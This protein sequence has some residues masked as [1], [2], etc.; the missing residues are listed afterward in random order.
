MSFTHH[1]LKK[2]ATALDQNRVQQR[3]Q[4]GRTLSYVEGWFVIQEANRIFGFDGWD[5]QMVHFERCFERRS[6][7]G[8]VCGYVARVAI[9]VRAG[10]IEIVREGTGFGQAA[11]ERL[12][13]AHERA[14]KASETDATK[15]ALATFGSRFG[16]MLY[17]K[18]EQAKAERAAIAPVSRAKPPSPETASRLGA[19]KPT[20][21]DTHPLPYRLVASDGTATE[22]RTPQSFCSGLR[23]YL[24]L[25]R[26]PDEVRRL[27]HLNQTVIEGLRS[28]PD[29]KNLH[30]DHYADILERLFE[31]RKESFALARFADEETFVEKPRPKSAT[32]ADV[33]SAAIEGAVEEAQPIEDA[34]DLPR[35]YGSFMPVPPYPS[36]GLARHLATASKSVPSDGSKRADPNARRVGRHPPTIAPTDP[37][38][39]QLR[40]SQISGGFSIDKSVLLLPSERRV[41][42]KAHL[43]FVATKPCLICE[44]LP[45]HAHHITFAQ[46]RGLSQKVSDEFTV[47]LCVAHHNDLHAFH[48]EASW[49]RNQKIEPLPIAN[50]LWGESVTR[51][52]SR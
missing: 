40:R 34:H 21:D 13:D 5:R 42:S 25:A 14:L 33:S 39:V 52:S 50:A 48:N 18:D 38:S 30:G 26:E 10:T 35:F 2:L 28:L 36:E 4:D 11:A 8:F 15:R 29:L 31:Q 17:D 24:E 19:K 32:A 20:H 51:D 3:E 9:R 7:E 23:Q 43:Q 49:W 22:V 16:L 44:Q 12:A 37:P 47:P 45:C 41:R 27:Q 1:Q 6:Q 46:P